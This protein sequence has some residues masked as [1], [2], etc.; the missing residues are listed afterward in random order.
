MLLSNPVRLFVLVIVFM[1]VFQA[2]GWWQK[3]QSEPAPLIS[4]TKTNLPFLAKEPEVFQAEFIRSDGVRESRSFYARKG[5]KWRFDWSVNG[6][7]RYSMIQADSLY[8]VRHDKKLYE[9]ASAGEYSN[10]APDFVNDLTNGLLRQRPYTTF[11]EIGREG[12]I[13]RYKVQIENS[14]TGEIFIDFDNTLGMIVRQ[15]F[16]NGTDIEFGFELRNIKLEADDSLFEIPA[17][18]RKVTLVK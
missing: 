10:A 15:E 14:G 18:Y 16:K 2:C 17:G 13:T 12:N 5:A 4:E 3:G 1:P 8:T 6:E 11:E 9:E 7:I